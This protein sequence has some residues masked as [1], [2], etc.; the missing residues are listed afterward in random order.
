MRTSNLAIVFTDIKG[1]TERTSKQ[2]LEQNEK[3]L[4]THN[5]MLAPLFKGLG[6]RIVKTI[7]DA[8]MV[9]FESPTSAVLA[10]V[11][12]QDALWKYNQ[13]AIAEEQLHVRVAIN[14]GEVRLEGNDVFGEP[15]NIAARVEGVAE[16]DEV[17]FTESVYLSMNRA[18]LACEELGRF[19]L[20]GIPEQIRLY[21][22]TRGTVAGEPP[23]ANKGLSRLAEGTRSTSGTHKAFEAATKV[24][25]STSVAASK[26][27]ESTSRMV[28]SSLVSAER[29]GMPRKRLA[30]LSAGAV[31]VL[32]LLYLVFG[33]SPIERAIA[34]AAGAKS[35]ERNKK[36]D[37]ARKLIAQEKDAKERSLYS[38]QLAEKLGESSAAG[39]YASAARAGAKAAE[40]RLID[41]LAH[42]KC[43]VRAAA[44]DALA[45]LQVKRARGALEDLAEDGGPDDGEQ[46]LLFGCNSKQAA[47]T[48]LRRLKD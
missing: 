15:V 41:L 21:K 37:V 4:K 7:G 1:F 32:A 36:V 44:A 39:H 31:V 43:G 9:T 24:M 38:G 40:G 18:E 10:G 42:P 35:E 6:G 48:A 47:A 16:A 33:K 2:T 25:E 12:V 23:F 13:S 17:T 34:D 26:A 28:E 11:A 30:F 19:E 45:D 14:V 29:Q 46:V 3:L 20:K 8:F 27:F 22:V 5:D